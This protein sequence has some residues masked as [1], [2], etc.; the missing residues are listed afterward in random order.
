[1]SP[2][3]SAEQI[4]G[5]LQQWEEILPACVT[6]T[7]FLTPW[8]QRTWWRHFGTGSRLLV[9]PLEAGDDFLGI[10]PLRTRDGVV[11]FIGDTDLC[12]YQDFIVIQG[13]ED[14]YYEALYRRLD[15][16]QW[17]TLDL[18]SVPEGSPTLRCVP[19][20]AE[21]MGYSV[22]IEEEDKAPCVRLA[23]TWEEQVSGLTKKD[24]HELRRKLRKV[25]RAGEVE[26]QAHVSRDGLEPQMMDFLRL[27]RASHPDKARFMN[28]GQ[29]G[30]LPRRSI[31]GCR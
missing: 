31:G 23:A 5:V 6:D 21:R 26:E 1:M 13:R 3:A 17:H 25:Q 11:S 28:P 19:A 24:R 10:A 2:L 4:E 8:W 16:E 20:V 7:V 27:M 22:S 29:G 9:L 15:R 14:A 18:K 12:D 30:I